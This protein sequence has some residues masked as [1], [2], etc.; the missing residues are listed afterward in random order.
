MSKSESRKKNIVL[1]IRCT[2]DEANAIREKAKKAGMTASKFLRCSALNR[3]I[4]TRTDTKLMSELLRLGGLQK[5]LYS[6]MKLGMTSEL[7]RQFSDVL[8]AIKKAIISLDMGLVSS[9]NGDEH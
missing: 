4:M 2:N 7:S 1:R 9:D 8:V 3:K 5:H 6:E